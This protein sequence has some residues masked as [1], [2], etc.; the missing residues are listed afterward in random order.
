MFII[1]VT[2][3]RKT[4]VL[5][6]KSNDIEKLVAYLADS[7]KEIT[8]GLKVEKIEIINSEVEQR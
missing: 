4:V 2:S 8:K 7:Y 5:P 3:K 1:K 6:T